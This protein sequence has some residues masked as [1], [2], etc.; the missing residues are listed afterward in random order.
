[1]KLEL[2]A[3]KQMKQAL[4]ALID[5]IPAIVRDA[6]PKLERSGCNLWDI[7]EDILNWE[8]E[9]VI[10]P[11]AASGLTKLSAIEQGRKT[12]SEFCNC[13][14]GQLEGRETLRLSTLNHCPDGYFEVPDYTELCSYCKLPVGESSFYGGIDMETFWL[15][16]IKYLSTLT[17]EYKKQIMQWKKDKEA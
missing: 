5:K 12:M 2:Q 11:F 8:G 9:L 17:S 16:S 10:D 13:L 1:M 6:L 4:Q 3:Y 15:F 7:N 14:V